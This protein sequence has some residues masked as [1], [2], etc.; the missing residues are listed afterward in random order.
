MDG[1]KTIKVKSSDGKLVELTSK[2]ASKS[3]LLRGIIED[4]PEDSEFPLNNVT[5]EVLEKI[6]EYLDHYQDTE[7][8][9]VEKPM[10]DEF[11]K[12]CNEWDNKYLGDNDMMILELIKGA[13]FMDIKPLLE[14]AS[15]KVASKIK[16][17]NTQAINK[18]F[19]ITVLTD[20]EK[21]QV[22]KD[23]DYLEKNL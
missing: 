2:A 18:S 17:V 16:K 13:N 20:E 6:K 23:K 4:Y 5:G 1:N 10:K 8:F 9:V 3:G 19:N 15:A 11:P 22:K 21:N 14:I 7:P 12:I